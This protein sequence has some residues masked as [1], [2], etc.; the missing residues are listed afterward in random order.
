[1]TDQDCRSVRH[2]WLL[3]FSA[4]MFLSLASLAISLMSERPT[5]PESF[6]PFLVLAAVVGFVGFGLCFA[7]Q[8]HNTLRCLASPYRSKR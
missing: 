7:K 4:I 1:M 2:A 8:I 3:V 5:P 6:R